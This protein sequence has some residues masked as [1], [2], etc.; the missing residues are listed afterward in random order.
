VALL[1][2]PYAAP[3]APPRGMGWGQLYTW[4]NRLLRWASTNN[5]LSSP[6]IT[7]AAVAFYPTPWESVGISVKRVDYQHYNVAVWMK[8]S[9][10]GS[11]VQK[12]ALAIIGLP[13]TYSYDWQAQP[14]NNSVAFSGMQSVATLVSKA[15]YVVGIHSTNTNI[16]KV[17]HTAA[18]Y[19]T[20]CVGIIG[21]GEAYSQTMRFSTGA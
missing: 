10:G 15:V 9:A 17:S 5:L 8:A 16:V 19:R 13:R 20:L 14:V 11:R 12:P 1:A 18:D 4:A 2:S 6:V 3:P 21:G 7:S